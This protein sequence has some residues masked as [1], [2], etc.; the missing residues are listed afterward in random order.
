MTIRF[1]IKHFLKSVCSKILFFF[2]HCVCINRCIKNNFLEQEYYME[3]P[4]SDTHPI[5]DIE[6]GQL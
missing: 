1:N 5:Y 6:K 2:T 3:T 4:D